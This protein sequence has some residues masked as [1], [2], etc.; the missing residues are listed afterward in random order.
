MRTS[1]KPIHI[2]DTVTWSNEDGLLRFK[3]AKGELSHQMHC[4]VQLMQEEGAI[5]FAA[6][7]GAEN[8][9]ALA[10]TTR[11][12]VNNIV[13][14]LTVGF[15]K[16]LTLFGVGYRAKMSGN[17]L[18]LTLGLSHPVDF[19]VPEGVSISTPSQT[20][21]LITGIDKQLIGQVAANIRKFRPPEPYKGKGI[22]YANEVIV[23]KEVNK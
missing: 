23:L 6:I 20:E 19:V 16:K 12:L 3:T 2:P 17:T 5:W 15:E 8:G 13:T 10:G 21:I 1:A 14:G 9:I 22:R 7:E 18:N 11:A 4:S